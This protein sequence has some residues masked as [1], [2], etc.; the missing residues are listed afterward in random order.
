MSNYGSQMALFA[1]GVNITSAGI[2]GP[3]SSRVDSGTSMA[4]PH[5]AGLIA[6]LTG[7]EGPRTP[8]EMKTRVQALARADILSGIP[9]GTMNLMSQNIL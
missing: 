3:N 2:N 1:P 9:N 7:L 4:A 5:V 8:P 6:Y